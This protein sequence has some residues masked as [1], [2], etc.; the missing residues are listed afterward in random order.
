MGGKMNDGLNWADES[1][2]ELDQISGSSGCIY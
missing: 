1:V 2:W